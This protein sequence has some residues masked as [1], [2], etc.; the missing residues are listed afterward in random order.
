MNLEK[1]NKSALEFVYKYRNIR[2]SKQK[3]VCP[4]FINNVGLNLKT[5]LHAANVDESKIKEI[6]DIYKSEISIYGKGQGKGTPEQIEKYVLNTQRQVGITL[7]N[8]SKVGI[9][10]FM[11]LFGIGVDCSGLVY[12][13]LHYAFKKSNLENE[14]I[15]S[16]DWRGDK[17]TAHRAGTFVFAGRAS[18]TV[19]PKDLRPLDIILSKNL[20]HIGLVLKEK[21]KFYLA[22]SNLDDNQVSI[23]KLE[24]LNNQ[25]SFSYKTTIARDW[26]TLFKEGVFEF[27]RLL[28]TEIPN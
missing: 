19:D 13:T 20:S 11:N 17:K 2:V 5:I 14:F 1:I 23:S 12:N 27:K 16:L 26:N 21:Q 10:N 18:K 8:A 28:I 7:E 22:Q 15:E 6:T 4:Y 9:R 25:P 3:I 24:V